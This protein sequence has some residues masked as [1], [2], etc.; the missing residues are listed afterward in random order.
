MKLSKIQ[1][2]S[3]SFFSFY[4]QYIVNMLKVGFCGFMI[5]YLAS[6]LIP[7]FL[8]FF[9]PIYLKYYHIYGIFV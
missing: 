6:F 1:G 4:N 3:A 2:I 8:A 9:I 7:F 5:I